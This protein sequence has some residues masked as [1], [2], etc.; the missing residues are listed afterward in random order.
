MSLPRL[1]A[2]IDVDTLA[3]NG[4]DLTSF[5]RE[6]HDAGVKLLQFRNK[7]SSVRATLNQAAALRKIFSTAEDTRL[8]LNDR[9]D[10]ALL[11]GFDGVHVGQDDLAAEDARTIM[12]TNAWV[13]VS[14]H[15][16]QQV[17][18]A[19]ETDC[20][21]IA[22]GPVFPTTSKTNPDPTVGIAGLRIARRLTRKPLIAIGGITRDNSRSVVDAGADSVAVISGLLPRSGSGSQSVQQIAEEFLTLLG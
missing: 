16:A 5:A 11:A 21:Y 9:A 14:T 3:A 18:E 12:G 2:I 17:I 10:L 7:Q 22:Y 19:N 13:G 20:D 15:S 1:Y 8:L 4:L 6:L